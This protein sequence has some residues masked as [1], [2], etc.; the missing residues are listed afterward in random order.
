MALNTYLERP[1]PVASV[2]NLTI[3][4]VSYTIT[5]PA[6]ISVTSQGCSSAQTATISSIP[7]I[8][9]YVKIGN[10]SLSGYGLYLRDQTDN[11]ILFPANTSTSQSFVLCSNTSAANSTIPVVVVGDNSS[12]YILNTSTIAV[13]VTSAVTPTSPT[14]LPASIV[15]SA[16]TVNVTVTRQGSIFYTFREGNYS[17][18]D[19]NLTNVMSL[20]G[21]STVNT[22]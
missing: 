20:L 21:N 5:I 19:M 7:T 13:T 8:A 18:S 14:I 9:V 4:N 15:G 11:N 1:I 6:T 17:S 3:S 2:V 16:A 10:G 22:I 12:Q